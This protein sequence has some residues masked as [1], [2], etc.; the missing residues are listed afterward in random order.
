MFFHFVVCCL[1]LFVF[2][3]GS[4]HTKR[5]DDLSDTEL[6]AVL[7][8]FKQQ[9]PTMPTSL[10]LLAA[11]LT[12]CITVY[13]F[14]FLKNNFDLSLDNSVRHT[15]RRRLFP[16]RCCLLPVARRVLFG[17]TVPVPSRVPV[18]RTRGCLWW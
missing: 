13:P 5:V 11:V 16:L 4:P 8:E 17:V 12:A 15:R 18:R 10:F 2:V 3:G 6:D 9:E 7:S 1:L 14:L